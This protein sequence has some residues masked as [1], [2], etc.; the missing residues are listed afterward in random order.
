MDVSGLWNLNE[1]EVEELFYLLV[2][3]LF[4]VLEVKDGLDRTGIK[5]LIKTA[6]NCMHWNVALD[7]L[8]G[9]ATIGPWLFVA[10][11]I[12]KKLL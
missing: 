4:G 3:N 10:I 6:K 2:F 12:E 1:M 9:S 8:S 7:A 11:Y 5:K